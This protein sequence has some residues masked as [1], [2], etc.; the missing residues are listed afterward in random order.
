MSSVGL[1]LGGGGITGA[2][3]HFGTLFALQM[4]TGWDP[5]DA[6]VIIGTSSGSFIAAMVRGGALNLDT[7]VGNS[8]RDEDAIDWLSANV[9]RRIRPRGLV[10]WVRTGIL[11]SITRPGLGVALGSPGIYSTDA[12][13]GWVEDSLGDLADGWP[14]RPT[15]IVAHDLE[16]RTRVPFGTEAG[17]VVPLKL[18]VAAS[19]AVPFVFEPVTIDGRT[20]ADGGVSSG[21]SIDLL[22]ANPE[23]LDLVIIV[24]PMAATGS[25][26][27]GRFYEEILDRAGRNA[28]AAEVDLL[29][30]EWPETDVLVLRPDH[31]V[32]E[33]TRANP[34]SVEAAIPSF[35]ATLRS[36][37]DELAHASTWSVLDRHIV[38]TVHA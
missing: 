28:L 23:P 32:L 36:M 14:D 15:V 5:A 27:G 6:D 12:M 16:T 17:P 4:A 3:Y 30:K 10:R 1:V 34:M 22:L 33:L 37:R 31:R 38:D 29:K 25:R 13:V 11:P 8:R 20:Y 21:T 18:A 7:M 24:A 2:A 19:S 9:Y 26:R 35:L